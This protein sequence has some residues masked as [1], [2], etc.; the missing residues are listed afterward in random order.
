MSSKEE[1]IKTFDPN[2]PV[3]SGSLFGLPFGVEHSELVVIPVPWDVTVSYRDGTSKGPEAILK[4]SLQVDLYLKSIF[5]AWKMGIYMMPISD[6]FKGENEIHRGL[7][8][9]YLKWL[10]TNEEEWI[11][12]NIK[13]IPKAIDDICEKLNIYVKSQALDLI[14]KGKMVALLGGDHSTPLGLI[15]ALG[16]TYNDFG[17]LQIDAHA[18]LRKSYENFTYSHASIMY[19]ALTEKSVSKLV[20]VGVRDYCEEE[21][22]YIS[23]SKGRV[24]TFFD[25]DIKDLQNEGLPWKTI[26]EEIISALPKN[27]YI[28]FD[29]DGLDPK[30]CPNT[31]TPVPGGL[32]YDQVIY[33][34]KELVKSGRKIIGF[35]LNEVAPGSDDWDANVGARILYQLGCLMGVSQ[36]K[37]RFTS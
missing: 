9:R 21:I 35:D 27:V 29:I 37:L 5:D 34:F 10:E 8:L 4:A 20:Q 13:V 2:G 25:E 23:N 1:I 6:S 12:D 7:A 22:I 15:K 14:K 33:L 24:V 16:S 30:L 31:G 18:D 28:S 11:T 26:C 32:E 17:I 3:T 36:R 19:N